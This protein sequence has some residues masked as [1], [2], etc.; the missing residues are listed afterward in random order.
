MKVYSDIFDYIDASDIPADSD[1]VEAPTRMIFTCDD[2]T[3]SMEKQAF[4]CSCLNGLF[5]TGFADKDIWEIDGKN[6]IRIANEVSEG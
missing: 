2:D 6:I 5:N 4:S 3:P 1:N